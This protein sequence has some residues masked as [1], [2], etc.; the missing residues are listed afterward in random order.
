[1]TDDVVRISDDDR[2]RLITLHRPD[3]LNA[4]NDALYDGVRD[5]L[6]GAAERSDIAVAVVTGAGRAFS[7]GQD[8]SPDAHAPHDGRPHG[9]GP[10]MDAVDSFPKPLI[11]A[12]NGLGVGIG[13]TFLL[14]CDVVLIASD[15]RLRAPFVSLGLTGE[16]SSTYLLPERIGHQRA[17]ELLYTARWVQA[18]EVVDIGLALRTCEPGETL[19]EATSLAR[20]IAAMP[21]PSLVETKRLLLAAHHAEVR[22]ARERENL[23]FGSLGGGPA[24]REAVA[25]FREKRE[26]DFSGL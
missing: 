21:V 19:D 9:F 16:A 11:A 14:H 8:L 1:V 24:N 13:L 25:A 10:F 23:A 3:V 26:P 2:V 4:F 15:A 22:A 20:E 5:A 7:A 18:Q 17:A 6:G 12:V